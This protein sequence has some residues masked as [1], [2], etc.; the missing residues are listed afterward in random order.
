MT[1]DRLVSVIIPV[2]NTEKYLAEC[3]D[4]L[5]A[6]TYTGFEAIVVDDG[7][8]DGSPAICD[9]YAARDPRFRVIHK[10]NGELSEARNAG[11]DTA[12]GEYIYF[13][14]SDDRI[15]PETLEQTVNVLSETGADFV[16]F[17]GRSFEDSPRGFDVPQTY[18]RKRLYSPREGIDLFRELQKHGE[19]RSGVPT[20][21]WKREFLASNSLR[22][23]PGV[24]YEDML[25]S[26]E[27]FCTAERVAHCHEP[28]YERRIRAGSIMTAKPGV[29]NY[30]SALTVYN[31][32][33][34]IAANTG[35]SGRPCVKKYL[36]R[37]AFRVFDLYSEITRADKRK[38]KPA[39]EEFVSELKETK[40]NGDR[41]LY[42][43]CYGRLPWAACRAV[44]K[45]KRRK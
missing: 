38:M 21:L 4:S 2:Y 33:V 11:L 20:Y 37:C 43:R 39:E 23:Y 44:Q 10:E 42:S 1:K 19:F 25:F 13:L 32:A 28:L 41:A 18:I 5:A 29:K 26:F 6:Q 24:L 31:E 35:F 15:L 34:K 14:D 9:G 16:F 30:E 17:D 36:S 22:F 40:G 12:S 7:S 27:A 45:L 8:T 3:L